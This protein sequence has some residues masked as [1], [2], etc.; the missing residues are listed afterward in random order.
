MA[1]LAALAAVCVVIAQQR[2]QP[3]GLL[4]IRPARETQLH[5]L[6]SHEVDVLKC[7]IVAALVFRN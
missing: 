1:A 7:T 6:T 4:E 2:N 3:G 5:I